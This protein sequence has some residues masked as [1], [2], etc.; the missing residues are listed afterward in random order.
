[1]DK[2]LALKDAVIA[3]GQISAEEVAS[4][5]AEVFADGKVTKEE[6]TVL[7]EIN[8]A[9]AVKD[10]SWVVLLG[11]AAKNA[12]ISD[13]ESYN[14]IDEAE[15]DYLI[16]AFQKDGKLDSAELEVIRKVFENADKINEKLVTFV[17]TALKDAVIADGVISDEEINT[18]AAIIYSKGGDQAESVSKE[19]AELVFT[20]NDSLPKKTFNWNKFFVDVICDFVLADGE[21]SDEEA[22]WLNG[23]I[24][25]NG[26]VDESEKALITAIKAK[27]T[28]V[29]TIFKF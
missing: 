7:F 8:D 13:S 4:L 27:A 15:A 9:C 24:S 6:L 26:T 22:T 5:E 29:S 1:M 3:D 28:K 20:I 25:A 10:P 23:Q 17:K 21:V 19:E 14:E 2:L 16:A 12:L 18:I 11:R